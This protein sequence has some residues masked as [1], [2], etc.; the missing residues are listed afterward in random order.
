MIA[1]SNFNLNKIIGETIM[2]S[3]L[4]DTLRNNLAKPL[5]GLMAQLKMA[6]HNRIIQPKNNKAPKNA[7]VMILFY[8]IEDQW[9]IV[10]IERDNS[11]PKD[12]HRGQIGFPGGRWE[13][14][15][16][17]FIQTALRETEEEVGV[18]ANSIQVIGELTS[19]YIDVSNFLVHPVVGYLDHQ[20]N[21]VPQLSEVKKI[22]TPPFQIFQQPSTLKTK[23]LKINELITL[24][25]HPY[26]HV[27]GHTVWG[28]TAM[29]LSELLELV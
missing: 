11:N 21:F 2:N 16:A 29:I 24:R 5:P 28:A 14:G 26:F 20:P 25:K 7:G 15:D 22:I 23:D 1:I 3:I 13:S 12:K 18:S 8:P 10:L 19:L 9:H 17:S 4:I 6:N 27:Q